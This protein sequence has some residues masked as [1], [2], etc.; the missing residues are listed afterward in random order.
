MSTPAINIED[1]L[2]REEE[3]ERKKLELENQQKNQN[4]QYALIALGMFLAYQ[5]YSSWNASKMR[6]RMRLNERNGKLVKFK[7]AMRHGAYGNHG[8]HH[9]SGNNK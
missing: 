1:L 4:T 8:G 3:E 2:M 9:G 5:F 6:R 7:L